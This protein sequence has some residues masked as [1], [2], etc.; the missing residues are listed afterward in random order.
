MTPDELKY[1]ITERRFR[2]CYLD[3]QEILTILRW[4]S[5]FDCIAVKHREIPEDAYVENV[6]FSDER[7]AW[8]IRLYHVSFDSVKPCN[9][10]PSIAEPACFVLA[11]T[12]RVARAS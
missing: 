4:R 6:T 2:I 5:E 11:K 10:G 9:I 1:A 7:R 3:A 12:D 8:M